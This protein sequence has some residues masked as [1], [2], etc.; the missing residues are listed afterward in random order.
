LKLLKKID[1]EDV[2]L[3]VL[4]LF[5]MKVLPTWGDFFLFLL[6]SVVIFFSFSFRYH[7]M[8]MSKRGRTG[9]RDLQKLRQA[10]LA[11]EKPSPIQKEKVRDA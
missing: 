5:M 3:G 8:V 6:L 1:T 7:L 2:F 9:Q 11:K 10:R 4:I